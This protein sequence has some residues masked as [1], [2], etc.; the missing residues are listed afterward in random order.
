MGREIVGGGARGRRHQHAV[1]DQFG[2][3]GLPSRMRIL[4]AWRVSRSS[5]TSLKARASTAPDSVAPSFSAGGSRP[6][7]GGQA[8]E[9]VVW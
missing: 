4:A 5:E 2:K 8:F 9:Q 6:F 1:A 7:G 3:R